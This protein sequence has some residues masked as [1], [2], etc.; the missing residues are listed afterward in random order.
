MT[1]GFWSKSLCALLAAGTFTLFPAR[2]AGAQS[3]DPTS[4]HYYDIVD[5]AHFWDDAVQDAEAHTYKGMQGY[6]VTITSQEE[7]DFLR[8]CIKSH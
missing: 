4:G 1:L 7:N 6:L 8:V 5:Q 2:P 3:L